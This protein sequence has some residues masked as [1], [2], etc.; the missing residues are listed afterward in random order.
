[1]SE[2]CS[3][4]D[5]LAATP[6]ESPAAT[7]HGGIVTD[8]PATTAVP[9]DAPPAKAPPVTKKPWWARRYTFTGTAVDASL[10]RVFSWRRLSASRRS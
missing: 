3:G 10:G 9:A 4:P 1:V 7:A 6:A 5:E 8:K 2:T